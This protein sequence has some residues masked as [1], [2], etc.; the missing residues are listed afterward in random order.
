MRFLVMLEQ[1]EAGFAVQVPDLAITTFGDDIE[2][3]KRA[4]RN[5]I[6]INLDAYGEAGQRVP[7]AQ[8]VSRHLDN[9]EFRDLLF[10][11]VELAGPGGQLAA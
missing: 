9:P 4:A 7:E 2:A 10:T 11:Y 1:T 8:P 6:R 3:A 5:A